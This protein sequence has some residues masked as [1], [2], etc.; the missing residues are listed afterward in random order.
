[1]VQEV[2]PPVAEDKS[3]AALLVDDQLINT[4]RDHSF[5]PI[6][7]PLFPLPL[8]MG[9]WVLRVLA[10]VVRNESGKRKGRGGGIFNSVVKS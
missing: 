1:M 4:P 7:I 3:A 6:P 2:G 10:L 9:V 5:S 8:S